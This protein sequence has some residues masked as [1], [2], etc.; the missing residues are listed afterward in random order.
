MR[1]PV[2]AVA[3]IVVIAAPAFAQQAAPAT[4]GGEAWRI[5]RPPQSS[6]VLARDG[7]LIGEIGKQWRTSVPLATLPRHLGQA[8]IAV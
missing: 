3:L 1:S 4:P 6:L 2:H 5:V 7:S 8:F